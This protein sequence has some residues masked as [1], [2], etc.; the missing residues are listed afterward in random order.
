MTNQMIPASQV[1]RSERLFDIPPRAQEMLRQRLI[2]RN[3]ADA[4]LAAAVALVL[5]SI[6]A[7]EDA[8]VVVSAD[9]SMYV[10]DTQTA[11]PSESAD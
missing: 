9:G 1:P 4:E 10:Q 6:D 2:A 3:Q 7:P 5:A 8:Q 11:I